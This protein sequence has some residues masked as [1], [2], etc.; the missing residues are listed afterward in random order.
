MIH[1]G[2]LVFDGVLAKGAASS[3]AVEGS[4]SWR[5]VNSCTGTISTNINSVD[6]KIDIGY[7]NNSFVVNN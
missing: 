6:N 3:R 4:G 5:F 2:R 1:N 7:R